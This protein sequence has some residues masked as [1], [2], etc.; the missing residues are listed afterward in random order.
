MAGRSPANPATLVDPFHRSVGAWIEACTPLA[1]AVDHDRVGVPQRVVA[2]GQQ[3]DRGISPRDLASRWIVGLDA[4]LAAVR[5]DADS[6]SP[7]RRGWIEAV[8]DDVDQDLGLKLRLAVAAHRSVQ[9]PWPPFV[10]GHRRD[11]GVP[12][13]LLRLE[14]IGV[15]RIEAE[16]AAAVLQQHSSPLGDDAGAEV[17]SD[18]LDERDEISL[19]VRR[20][21]ID[22]VAAVG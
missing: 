21:H 22:G 9:E 2:C 14:S 4:Y 13:A 17:E 18:A 7:H 19:L 20:A 3:L 15:A 16:V 8:V 1:R 10:R 5:G 12:R 6:R 11:E